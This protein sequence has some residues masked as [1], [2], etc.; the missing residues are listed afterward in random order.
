MINR[1]MA[2]ERIGFI[3]VLKDVTVYF[4]IVLILLIYELILYISS[5][6]ITA[7]VQYFSCTESGAYSFISTEENLAATNYKRD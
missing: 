3:F 2:T 6:L 5:F 1:N 7:V 4:C